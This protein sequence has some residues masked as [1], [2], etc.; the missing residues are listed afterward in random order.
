VNGT[1]IEIVVLYPFVV[2]LSNHYNPVQRKRCL[3]RFPFDKLRVNGTGIEIVVL[4]PF[5]VSLSNHFNDFSA[6]C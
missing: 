4:Y 3:D 6:A 1:G 5:V 2:S